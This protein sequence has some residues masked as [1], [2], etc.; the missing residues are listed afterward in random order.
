MRKLGSIVLLMFILTS[1]QNSQKNLKEQDI[2]DSTTVVN[3]KNEHQCDSKAGYKWSKIKQDCIKIF[4]VGFR[5]NPVE[6]KK[7]KD[8]VS[9]FVLL[10]E[11]QAKLELFLPDDT[12]QSVIL[13]KVDDY[14]Y[15]D[16]IYKYDAKK[17]VLYSDGKVTY[18][19]NV[20]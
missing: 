3:A 8:A 7:G 16:G 9:A 12:L 11:D 17:S 10:S 18:K 4:N 20:E 1:C 14:N 2:K 19:G 6:N 13:N 5:L 15:Q